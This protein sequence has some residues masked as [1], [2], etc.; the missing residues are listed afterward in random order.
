MSGVTEP[1]NRREE[2]RRRTH[3]RIYDTAIRLF[4]EHGFEQVSVNRIAEASGVSVPTFYAHYASK[5]DLLLALPSTEEVEGLLDTQPAHLPASDQVRGAIRMWVQLNGPEARAHVLE[6]WRI[7][8]ATP[9]L[10]IRAAEFER[11][12][13]RMVLDA[14]EARSPDGSSATAEVTVTAI[15]AAYTQILLRW[16]ESN[17]TARLEEI[18]EAV[19]EQ[20][21]RL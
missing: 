5:E 2:K 18:A 6:R 21:R 1:P 17:G 3:Q 15:L 11:R 7:V 8:A 12:T 14:I 13:A 20:L 16:A 19:L 10:R 4:Q 9:T